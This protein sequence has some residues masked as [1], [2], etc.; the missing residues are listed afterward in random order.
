MN[1]HWDD[2]QNKSK[3]KLWREEKG[4]KIHDPGRPCSNEN[5]TKIAATSN[6][7]AMLGNNNFMR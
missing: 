7:P 6:I 3:K 4:N 1:V 5:L 2:M